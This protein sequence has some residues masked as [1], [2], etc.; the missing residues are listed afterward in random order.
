MYLDRY[1]AIADLGDGDQKIAVIQEF[2]DCPLPRR[3]AGRQVER[4]GGDGALNPVGCQ[5]PRWVEPPERK[6]PRS[7][8]IFPCL[9]QL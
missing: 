3:M 5:E 4:P 8:T 7:E 6:Q 1:L 2:I 9:P